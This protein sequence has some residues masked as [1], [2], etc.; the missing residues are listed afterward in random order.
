MHGQ[1]KLPGSTKAVIFKR[2]FISFARPC[3]LSRTRITHSP[4]RML[5]FQAYML[6]TYEVF[7]GL[8]H[9]NAMALCA[10]H[11]KT[12]HSNLPIGRVPIEDRFNKL[13]QI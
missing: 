7:V 2:G 5:F 3:R 4:G 11:W 12:V 9:K 13:F 6:F 1:A 10:V 8:V